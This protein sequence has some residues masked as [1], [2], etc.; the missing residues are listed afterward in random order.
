[1]KTEEAL[2]IIQNVIN[3][4]IQKGLFVNI[5]DVTAVAVA[6]KTIEKSLKPKEDAD[7]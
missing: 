1:M 2:Q 6:F 4:G 3:A 5:D 7:N